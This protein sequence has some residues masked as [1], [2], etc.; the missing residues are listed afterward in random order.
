[1]IKD[2]IMGQMICPKCG[3]PRS[4]DIDSPCA[5]GHKPGGYDF[6]DSFTLL[7]EKNIK[8]GQNN[9]WSHLRPSYQ[10]ILRDGYMNMIQN[11]SSGIFT[12]LIEAQETE[13]GKHNVCPSEYIK[14][15][16]DVQESGWR[17]PTILPEHIAAK[18]N[19][20]MGSIDKIMKVIELGY[21]GVVATEEMMVGTTYFTITY[22]FEKGDYK[23][24]AEHGI[25]SFPALRSR[26]QAEEF[27]KNNRDLLDDF[28]ML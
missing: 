26:Q 21:G 17:T 8:Q 10:K 12:E 22:S 19:R 3:M 20:K 6:P 1:M 4:T 25:I 24:T 5:C 9:R 11:N 2:N 7:E 13:F 23:I 27:L 15:W 18:M 14:T 16:K 28:N